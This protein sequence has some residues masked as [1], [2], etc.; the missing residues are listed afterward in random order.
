LIAAVCGLGMS[1]LT[2][3]ALTSAL[4][5]SPFQSYVVEWLQRGKVTMQK[6]Q[7]A[8]TIIQMAWRQYRERKMEKERQK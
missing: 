3:T 2:I 7:I 4:G 6:R 1:S 5:A 8:A